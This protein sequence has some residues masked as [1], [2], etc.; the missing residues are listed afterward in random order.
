MPEGVEVAIGCS[1]PTSCEVGCG[2]L[3][4]S[5]VCIAY[6]ESTRLAT[7]EVRANRLAYLVGER[8]S[9]P[10]QPEHA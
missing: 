5:V 6:D 7:F 4:Y 9:Y 10:S 8:K 1:Y 3:H 2:V